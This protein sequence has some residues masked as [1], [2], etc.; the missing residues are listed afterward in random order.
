MKVHG[1]ITLPVV[2]WGCVIWSTTLREERRLRMFENNVVDV[3]FRPMRDE[4]QEVG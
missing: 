4:E 1:S 3:I 2:L